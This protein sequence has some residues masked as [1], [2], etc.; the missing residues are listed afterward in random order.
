LYSR[1]RFEPFAPNEAGSVAEFEGGLELASVTVD[2]QAGR[3]TFDVTLL[4]RAAQAPRQEYRVFVHAVTGDDILA[5]ADGPLGTKL[6][7]ASW[8]RPGEVVRETHSLTLMPAVADGVIIRLGLYAPETGT[9]LKRLDVP[10]DSL[11]IAP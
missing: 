11:E 5:Q 6:Y 10:G 8:W 7:P 3:E 4:W 2:R 1:Y 9:R